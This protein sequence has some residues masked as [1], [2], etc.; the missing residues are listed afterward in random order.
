MRA[1][2][3]TIPFSHLDEDQLETIALAMFEVRHSD[4]EDIITQVG[5]P[6]PARPHAMARACASRSERAIGVCA[7][8][9]IPGRAGGRG[10]IAR[11]SSCTR[12]LHWCCSSIRCR[13]VLVWDLSRC[14]IARGFA[15][16]KHTHARTHRVLENAKHLS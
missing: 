15:P 7:F 9:C 16:H 5:A 11:N 4:G 13:G 12:R 6:R 2:K 3:I 14:T 10:G 8:L 1:V